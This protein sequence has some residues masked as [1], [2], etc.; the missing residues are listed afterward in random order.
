MGYSQGTHDDGRTRLDRT[1]AA[2]VL[3]GYSRG[4]HGVLTGYSRGTHGVLTGYSRGTPG[5]LTG[6]SRGTHGVLTG[7]S[8][9]T[10][11][12]L[13]GYSRGTHGVLMGY[14]WGTHRVLTT[15]D[16][17]DSTVQPR[18]T[19]IAASLCRTGDGRVGQNATLPRK[20]TDTWRVPPSG[21]VAAG[22]RPASV[23]L[24]AQGEDGG[25]G[26]IERRTESI[27]RNAMRRAGFC[28]A[29][30]AARTAPV[31]RNMC[32][33]PAQRGRVRHGADR[34]RFL[35]HNAFRRGPSGPGQ[36]QGAVSVAMRGK[37]AR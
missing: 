31:R 34:T 18:L 15:T 3:T 6:Y 22:R 16:A 23:L 12:V 9:G 19:C 29:L 24:I 30:P 5:V 21:A 32:S 13:T 11:G 7:Y 4:T 20:S 10:H 28:S 2:D 8:R 27:G 1:A 14:S 26:S 33:R 25:G 35:A 17:P 37:P 36:V